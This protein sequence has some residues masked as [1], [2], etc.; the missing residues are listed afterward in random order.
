MHFDVEY[1]GGLGDVFAQSYHNNSLNLFANLQPQ[2]TA[3]VF[4]VCANPFAGELF[5]Y[6]PNRSQIAVRELGYWM[7][8]H[9]AENRRLHNMPPAGSVYRLPPQAGPIVFYPSAQDLVEL[10]RFDPRATVVVAASAGLSDRNIPH[11]ML[12]QVV[13]YLLA[14]TT[15]TIAYT[16]R[17]FDRHGR[18]EQAPGSRNPRVLNLIDKLS[19]PGTAY[20][21]QQC[22]GLVTAHSALNLLGWHEH[23]PQLLL[24]PQS[25][26]NRH[27]HRRA[28]GLM[29]WDQWMF[30]AN[31]PNTQHTVF[32]LFGPAHTAA[33]V[34]TLWSAH[35][36]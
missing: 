30:G 1:G 33:F 23:K 5:A 22:K 27:S 4:F 35:G 34:N 18:I 32:E 16:G 19:V 24:Y 28:D 21:V 29:Q 31:R 2:D 13:D 26:V 17:T 11:D 25:V 15:F 8:D 20:L 14:T 36:V 12:E 9:D 10:S 7:V 3:T 6:H